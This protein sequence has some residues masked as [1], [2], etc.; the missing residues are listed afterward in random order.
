[1]VNLVTKSSLPQTITNIQYDFTV[2][3]FL[4]YLNPT[5]NL[6]F[7]LFILYIIIVNNHNLYTILNSLIKVGVSRNIRL[8]IPHFTTIPIIRLSLAIFISLDI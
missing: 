5:S 8:L 4:A 3:T 6:P 1:M 2:P 7:N